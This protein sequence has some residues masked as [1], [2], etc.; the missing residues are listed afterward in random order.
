MKYLK[1]V[2]PRHRMELRAEFTV[3][4]IRFFE[5]AK[6]TEHTE[7]LLYSEESVNLTT[8]VMYLEIRI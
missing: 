7:D 5:C 6:R 3:T 4:E 1:T 2:H 8:K